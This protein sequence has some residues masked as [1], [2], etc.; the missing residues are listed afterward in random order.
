MFTETTWAI[1]ALILIGAFGVTSMLAMGIYGIYTYDIKPWYKQ[2]TLRF[3]NNFGYW[4]AKDGL[5]RKRLQLVV[6]ERM[7]ILATDLFIHNRE[8]AAFQHKVKQGLVP[9][10]EAEREIARLRKNAKRYYLRF[11][12]ARESASINGF[13]AREYTF[14]INRSWED[15]PKEESPES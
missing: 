11:K 14:Y 9:Y 3:K 5:L 8:E 1:I 13:E 6:D 4:P 12:N 15:E 2:S 10:G 7:E